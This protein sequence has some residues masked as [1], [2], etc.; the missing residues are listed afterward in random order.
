MVLRG[1]LVSL[2][3]FSIYIAGA[4]ANIIPIRKFDPGFRPVYGTSYSFEQ[5][6]WYGLEPREAYVKLLDEFNFDWA[7]LPFF[8]DEM[9]DQSGKLVIDD[10]KF[11]IE[12]A[13]KRNVKVVIALGVK[14]PYYPEF[15]LPNEVRSKIKFGNRLTADHPI[16][17][18][19][20]EVDREVVGELSVYDNIIFWQ[21]ENEPLIGNVNRWKIDPS[22]VAA[23]VDV[24]RKTDPGKR[25]IILN[26]AAVGFY[27][28][29]W[30]EL[31]PILKPGDVFAVNAFF[32]TKG[33]DLFNAKI[34]NREIHIFW[35]DHFVWP[36]YSWGLASPD[37][38]EIKK[39]VE[40][41]GNRFWILEMQAEPYIKKLEEAQD[42]FL[43]FE[44]ADIK[45]ADSF[46]KSYEIESV[47]LW[48]AHFWQYREKK[49][50]QTWTQTIKDVVNN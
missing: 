1:I 2:L 38:S 45:A 29:S 36:V 32:K 24:V 34:F 48:G 50:D 10:L 27:D 15:H 47:G 7:R 49:G 44:P 20:I 43:S 28:K 4:F 5:A 13:K 17:K 22:L 41:N 3:L 30:E 6:G 21:V 19:L 12:E 16:A 9:V 14:T 37:L 8:W 25:P 39:K 35:P 18:D 33:I 42:L 31:L 11:A 26:H 40:A 46:L 23:E